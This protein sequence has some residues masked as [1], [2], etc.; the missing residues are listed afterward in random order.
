MT[1]KVR[2]R[3]YRI[4]QAVGPVVLAYGIASENEVAVWTGLFN[5]IIGV[6]FE[7][8]ARNVPEED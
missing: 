5:A 4:A 7:L 6:P 8:A 1:P 2:K 3:I